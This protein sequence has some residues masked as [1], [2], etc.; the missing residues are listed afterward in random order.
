MLEDLQLSGLSESTQK[1]YL[2]TVR[3][4]AKHYMQ[5]P[6]LLSEEQVRQYFL[7][8]KNEKKQ[9]TS[10]LKMAYYGIRFFY[11]HTVPRDWATLRNIRF[12]REK[13]LP[14][15]LSTS[16][17][18]EL[19][20]AVRRPDYRTFLLVVYSLGLRLT[21]ALSLQVRDIDSDRMMVHIHRG[22]GAKD[23]YIPLPEKTLQA[24]RS[25]WETHRNPIWIFPSRGRD[26]RQAPVATRPLSAKSAQD[27]LRRIVDGLS[28]NK[29]G[30][31][32][33]TLRHSYATHLLESGVNLRLIQKYLG[34]NSLQTTTLYLHLTTQGE[35]QARDAINR[36]VD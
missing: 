10:S 16:E 11:T 4:L 20:A 3:L 25:H 36:L 29:Q 7:F 18:R 31:S 8:L 27:C 5:S 22:K 13:K 6:D 9:A 14:T 33:H 26:Y 12:I 32:I 35:E 23:R 1:Y 30:V 17:V 34:H 24:L 28:W 2:L 21:E 15:V 19:L